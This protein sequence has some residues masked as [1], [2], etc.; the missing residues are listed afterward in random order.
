MIFVTYHYPEHEYEFEY[1]HELEHE[2]KH[3]LE[4]GYDLSII[5]II[6]VFT[7]EEKKILYFES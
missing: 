2:Y 7:Q 3:E 5:I 1:E 6:E 4:H